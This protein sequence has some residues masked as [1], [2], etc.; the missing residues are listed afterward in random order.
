M[1]VS[2]FGGPRIY[3]NNTSDISRNFVENNFIRRNGSS[4]VTGSIDMTGNTFH[5][6]ALP[7]ADQDVATK[8]YVDSNNV[9]LKTYVDS[10]KPIITIWAEEDGVLE[11][12][13]FEWSFG[14]GSEGRRHRHSGYCMMTSG[15]VLIMGLC[16]TAGNAGISRE[17]TVNVVVNGREK[18]DYGVTVPRHYQSGITQFSVPL[19]LYRTDR[20]NFRSYTNNDDVTSAVVSLLIQI[21]V[22]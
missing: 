21:D 1:S 5:N 17:A 13:K 22:Y 19:E 16:A 8:T 14:N 20:I 11:R 6:V 7:T 10:R 3:N 12:D 18:F 2:K 4:A 15:R 9:T